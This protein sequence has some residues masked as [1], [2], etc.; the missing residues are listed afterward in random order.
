MYCGENELA[1]NKYIVERQEQVTQ[2]QCSEQMIWYISVCGGNP[3]SSHGDKAMF[4]GLNVIAGF[5]DQQVDA[6]VARQNH[7]KNTSKDELN[8]CFVIGTVNY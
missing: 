7:I 4:K 6:P 3:F 2:R 5:R 8:H 1:V